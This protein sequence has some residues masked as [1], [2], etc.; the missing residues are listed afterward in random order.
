MM[1]ER[2]F[3]PKTWLSLEGGSDLAIDGDFNK[4]TARHTSEP[5]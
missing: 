1:Y 3:S 4:M 5:T 2:Y